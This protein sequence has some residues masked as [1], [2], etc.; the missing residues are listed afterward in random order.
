MTDVDSNAVQEQGKIRRAQQTISDSTDDLLT[1]R[2]TLVFLIAFRILN[3]LCVKTFFQPDEYF[4]SLEPAWQIAFGEGS[5]AWITWVC[6]EYAHPG[7]RLI[8][9]AQEWKHN[10][11]SAIHPTLFAGVYWTTSKLSILLGLSPEPYAELMVAAPKVAQAVVAA[12]GDYYTWK[13]GQKVYG[14]GSR[15]AW[16]AVCSVHSNQLENC[17]KS[18]AHVWLMSDLFLLRSACLD[19]LQPLAMVL[20]DTYI[21][22]LPGDDAHSHR[23]RLVAMALVHPPTALGRREP[24]WRQEYNISARR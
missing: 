13:L 20:F 4:Q 18:I 5:G 19:R 22:E 8:V 21:V 1:S 2:N 16:A 7:R 3:A 14:N 11:R 15:E 10:L 17:L 9:C 12:L 24:G 6:L 23:S